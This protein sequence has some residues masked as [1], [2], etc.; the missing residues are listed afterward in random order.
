VVGLSA[1]QYD[2]EPLSAVPSGF[3][4][5]VWYKTDAEIA[6]EAA[7]RARW[8]R[9]PDDPHAVAVSLR[10]FLRTGALGPIRLGMTRAAVVDMLGKPNAW[11]VVEITVGLPEIFKYGDIEF[12]FDEADTLSAVHADSF[13]ILSGGE[14]L[15][16]DS[17]R[18]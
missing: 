7:V 13:D 8:E 16:L 14:A 2:Y 3:E 15:A 18:L 5:T 10:E 11:S 17:W 1:I 6:R 4:L 12:Y 9:A